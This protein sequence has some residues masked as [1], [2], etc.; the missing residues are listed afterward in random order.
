MDFLHRSF[1][2]LHERDGVLRVPLCLGEPADL[3]PQL[4]ADREP[5]ASSAARLMRKPEESFSIASESF[6]E[7]PTSWRWAL[8]ASMLF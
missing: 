7:V 6:P 3:C 4:L 1:R 2:R 8:N 5:A